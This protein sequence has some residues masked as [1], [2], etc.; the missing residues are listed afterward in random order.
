MVNLSYGLVF[1]KNGDSLYKSVH[2]ALDDTFKVLLKR[3]PE[4]VGVLPSQITSK[5]LLPL[6]I[7]KFTFNH[8]QQSEIITDENWC[9]DMFE[10]CTSGEN[11]TKYINVLSSYLHSVKSDKKIPQA[12]YKSLKQGLRIFFYALWA[13]KAVLLPFNFRYPLTNKSNKCIETALSIYPEPLQLIKNAFIKDND[14]EIIEELLPVSSTYLRDN[15]YKILIATNWYTFESIDLEDIPK[16]R[17]FYRTHVDNSNGKA[18]NSLPFN[19]LLSIFKTYAPD[20]CKFSLQELA[21]ICDKPIIDKD[22]NIRKMGLRK[23][24]S[25]IELQTASIDQKKFNYNY[26]DRLIITASKTYLRSIITELLEDTFSA[27]LSR[28]FNCERLYNPNKD[29]ELSTPRLIFISLFENLK[30]LTEEQFHKLF[31]MQMLDYIS[32]K[33]I[34]ALLE[35]DFSNLESTWTV[36]YS[37]EFKLSIKIFLLLSFSKEILLLPR[38]FKPFYANKVD[39]LKEHYPNSIIDIKP[40]GLIKSD[41]SKQ[42]ITPLL[43]INRD[44][45]TS[46]TLKDIRL[47]E[48]QE[49]EWEKDFGNLEQTNFDIFKQAVIKDAESKELICD[50]KKEQLGSCWIKYVDTY[51]GELTTSKSNINNK[52]KALKKL[53]SLITKVMPSHLGFSHTGL[54]WKPNLFTRQHVTNTEFGVGLKSHLE[55]KLA[56]ETF[57]TQLNAISSF[58]D[59]LELHQSD[60]DIKGF[61]NPIIDHIDTKISKRRGETG[62]KLFSKRQFAPVWSFTAALCEFYWYLVSNNLY[63]SGQAAK[64]NDVYD[65]GEL[66]FIPIFFADKKYY[67]ILY[68]P[69]RFTSENKTILNNKSYDYPCFQSLFENFIALETGIRHIH[70]RHIDINQWREKVPVDEITVDNSGIIPTKKLKTNNAHDMLVNT[71]KVKANSWT[72][73]VSS[74]VVNT[75]LKLES[76]AEYQTQSIPEVEYNDDQNS[77]YPLIKPIMHIFDSQKTFAGVLSETK[78]NTQFK[79]LQNLFDLY[80][81]IFQIG[82]PKLGKSSRLSKNQLEKLNN[83]DMSL[84][85]SEVE[86]NKTKNIILNVILKTYYSHSKYKTDITP[87]SCRGTVASHKVTLL[88][89]G[90][91]KDNITGHESLA[92]LF[93]YVKLDFEYLEELIDQNENIDSNSFTDIINGFSQLSQKDLQK[94]IKSVIDS[95]PETSLEDL[96]AISFSL[97]PNGNERPKSGLIAIQNV[98]SS[99]LAFFPTHICPFGGKCPKDVVEDIGEFM[100]GTCYYS[101]KTVDNIPSILAELRKLINQIKNLE[102]IIEVKLNTNPDDASLEKY[103]SE[104]QTTATS[105][106]SWCYSYQVLLDRLKKLKAKHKLDKSKEVFVL[107]PKALMTY[108]KD[109]SLIDTPLSKAVL[110]EIDSQHCAE[111]NT[112]EAKANIAQFRR[113]ILISTKDIDRLIN[114][115]INESSNDKE[116]GG[117]LSL[118]NMV[119]G[120]NLN[121]AIRN[122]GE[123][124]NVDKLPKLMASI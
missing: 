13:R 59:W 36:N 120:S 72:P 48:K 4:G 45:L 16:F 2:D 109:M 107:K 41:S 95:S 68:I 39:W 63:K 31:S 119:D 76:F 94:N 51:L 33:D 60:P 113:K 56:P 70:I 80:N 50:S 15:S 37:D 11:D 77:T 102:N 93:Y 18:L 27:L 100:C 46:I 28:H 55:K 99:Q 52:K 122:L 38:N 106:A 65:T 104:R 43:G 42:V 44:E 89:P 90:A 81:E 79:R 74:R 49:L 23:N 71:D 64:K 21:D 34:S 86:T 105:I 35:K 116:Y 117:V 103:E 108:F 124:I 54:P 87:H 8:N 121:K 62:K 14:Y 5:F 78:V 1:L 75:F 69:T 112:S 22:G 26:S 30:S 101:V 67:P 111:F 82:I 88:P 12:S 7:L 96:G 10:L 53:V 61:K 91:V 20:R 58:F 57:N 29:Y 24:L 73:I 92:C 115:E 97:P 98:N 118:I 6:T 83:R 110:Q 3:Y 25:N 114:E 9:K 84:N 123:D 47:M 19:S 17:S 32:V 40:N 66:G 85:G